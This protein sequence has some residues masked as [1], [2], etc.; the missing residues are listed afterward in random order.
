MPTVD[1]VNDVCENHACS[2]MKGRSV[3][4]LLSPRIQRSQS[5]LVHSVVQHRCHNCDQCQACDVK[6]HK[7]G[8][9]GILSCMPIQVGE[10]SPSWPG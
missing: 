3:A 1:A 10:Y 2:N 9:K 7:C 4:L 6:C 5:P 8:E